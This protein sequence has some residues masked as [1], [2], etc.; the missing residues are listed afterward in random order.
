MA[1]DDHLAQTFPCVL[2]KG[3]FTLD[4]SGLRPGRWHLKLSRLH[5]NGAAFADEFHLQIN[6]HSVPDAALNE[7]WI[8]ARAE[9]AVMRR[10]PEALQFISEAAMTAAPTAEAARKLR[11]LRTGGLEPATPFDLGTVQGGTAM[12][13]DAAWS[14]AK[15]GWGQVARNYFWFDDQIQNGVFLMLNGK[16]HDKG[17]YAHSSARFVFPLAGRWKKFTATIGLRDGANPQGSAVFT[18]RGDGRELYRSRMLR[19]GDVE[20]VKA[21]VAQVQQLELLTEGGEGHNHNSWAISG[22]PKVQR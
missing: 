8:V 16:F 15:V 14:E 1:K 4:L 3:A 19:V 6:E 9:N 20:E 11:L 2:Q 22:R 12:L 10:Q 5:A 18:V 7:E 17:L 21:D 13:S